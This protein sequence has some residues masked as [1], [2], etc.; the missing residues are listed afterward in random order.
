MCVCV[1]WRSHAYTLSIWKVDFSWNIF[2]EL[3]E[4]VSIHE[5]R[6]T[7][8]FIELKEQVSIY[9][10]KLT[11]V[12]NLKC[13]MNFMK[14]GTN[15]KNTSRSLIVTHT[16]VPSLKQKFYLQTSSLGCIACSLWAQGFPT[17][18][19]CGPLLHHLKAF[20]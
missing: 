4:W 15:L 13:K 20:P 10:G 19:V 3:E 1:A 5:G 6:L 12:R 14:R 11:W 18:V 17:K 16:L 8:V 2:I 9:E 7:W